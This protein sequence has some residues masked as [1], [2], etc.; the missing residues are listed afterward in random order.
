MSPTILSNIF[1][2]RVIPYNVRNPVS[3]KMPKG[4]SVY[5]VTKTLSQLGSKFGA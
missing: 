1:A 3:F 5:N 2:S 4:Y